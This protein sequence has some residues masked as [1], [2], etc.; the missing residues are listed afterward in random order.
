LYVIGP[1]PSSGGNTLGSQ[2]EAST[3]VEQ[4]LTAVPNVPN[5]YVIG[6]MVVRVLPD[7][8][9]VPGKIISEVVYRKCYFFRI[10][11]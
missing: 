7:G 2:E 11:F 4:Y 5:K 9:P 8:R 1:S 10:Q 6:P 3:N